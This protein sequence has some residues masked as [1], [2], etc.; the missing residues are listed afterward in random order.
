[1]ELLKVENLTVVD[2]VNHEVLVE[3]IHFTL[4]ENRCLGI[5]GESGSGK[6]VSC[7]AILGLLSD[8]LKVTGSAKYRGNELIGMSQEELRKV[9]ADHITMVMQDAM[10]AFDPLYT[11]GFQMVETL[12]EV[13]GMSKREAYEESIRVLNM[14]KMAEPSWVMKKFPHQLSGGMLQRCMIGLAL[15][16]KPHIIVADEPTTALDSINQREVVESFLRLRREEGVSLIFIS[17]DLGVV[18]CLADDL[19]VMCGGKQVESGSAKEIFRHPK[20]EYTRYLIR[21]RLEMTEN[22][23]RAMKGEMAE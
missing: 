16:L 5:V 18:Q 13:R 6:S 12:M 7:K 9:R 23:R 3:N 15:A 14:M 19:M 17:H 20:E 22:F 10:S 1:M 4:E 11:I 21:T 2:R 8:T